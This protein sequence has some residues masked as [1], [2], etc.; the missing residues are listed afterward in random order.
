MQASNFYIYEH[1]RP[2]TGMVFYVGKG[3]GKRLNC[4]KAGG[5]KRN[6]H[7]KAVVA[8]AGGFDARKLV[9]NIDEELAFLIEEERIDQLKRL[10]IKLTNKTLGGCGGIKGYSHTEETKKKIA[11]TRAKT[12]KKENHHRFGRFGKDNPMYGSK[13]SEKA[14]KGMSDNCCMKRPEVVAKISGANSL[15]AKTVEYDGQLFK[16]INDLAKHLG[17]KRSTLGVQIHRNP[18]KYGIRV[19]GKTKSLE[20]KVN[21]LPI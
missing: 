6:K 8:K 1:I 18:G 5:S 20:T 4:G 3:C 14:R 9:D 15:L 7:W 2:D 21:Q 11:E 16:T 10:G 13:Q 12:Y 19:L 17:I